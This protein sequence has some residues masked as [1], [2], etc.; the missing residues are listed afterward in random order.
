MTIRKSLPFTAGTDRAKL[1][2]NLYDNQKGD[3]HKWCAMHTPTAWLN[4]FVLATP[5]TVKI[6]AWRRLCRTPSIPLS[7]DQSGTAPSVQHQLNMKM[8]G[9]TD[10][11]IDDLYIIK[12]SRKTAASLS[13]CCPT[14]ARISPSINIEAEGYSRATRTPPSADS[15]RFATH[16]RNVLVIS[17]PTTAASLTTRLS[18]GP[19]AKLCQHVRWETMPTRAMAFWLVV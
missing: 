4:V 18:G 10:D 13:K 16:C 14:C 12:P 15:G 3:N 5:A 1:P 17:P 11:S 9:T 2:Q 19:L 8:V 6:E 7:L